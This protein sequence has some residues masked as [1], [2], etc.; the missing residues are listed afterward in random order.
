MTNNT[1]SYALITDFYQLTMAQGFWKLKKHNQL[2]VF[3]LYFR[4][5]PFQNGYIIFCGLKNFLEIVEN[6]H[7]SLEDLDYLA[8]LKT[9]NKNKVFEPQFLSF[10][11]N[12][13]FR[14]RIDS[15]LEGDIVFAKEPVMKISGT[16]LECQLL[17]TILLNTIN[18]QSLIATKASRIY[19][20]AKG[21]P[22]LE[23]GLRRAQGKDGALAA[24]RASYIGGCFAT[25]NVLAGKH[26]G[27]TVIG[28]HSHSWVVSFE[29]EKEA[30]RKYILQTSEDFSF[31]IDTYSILQGL[32]NAII[33]ANEQ[34]DAKKRFFAVRIDS[35]DIAYFSKIIRKKLDQAG[36]QHTKIIAS[37]DLDEHIIDSLYQQNAKIDI[38]AVGTKLVTAKD[39]P[40]MHGVYK[41]SA[42]QKE[43]KW[44]YRLK[45]S[46][47]IEKT[48]DPGILQVAR[49]YEKNNFLGDVV[50]NEQ[51]KEIWNKKN[52]IE[53]VNPNN[54]IQRKKFSKKQ[55]FKLLL[56]TV[57]KQGKTCYHFSDIHTVRKNTIEKLQNLDE[58]IKRL[59][60]PH[61]YPVGLEK[62]LF[63]LKQ[64]MI[65]T[66]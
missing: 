25:S 4:K 21:K 44:N 15:V 34:K 22:I 42:I 8:S 61:I 47:D 49:F 31:L 9:N 1:T 6:Y 33:V 2:A 10:L 12:F 63:E 40:A 23:F 28:T 54:P 65:L 56:Q 37:N 7:F 19:N 59:I 53:M 50:F 27:I 26:Y 39:D 48:S 30:F 16:L 41:L 57:M 13:V 14:C 36:F 38:W 60:N 43:K 24:S 66:K 18:F 51:E 11:K 5:I 64:K 17:E 62:N 58:S 32:E 20:V 35:G 46:E 3:H 52:Y 55:D 45:I 29:D